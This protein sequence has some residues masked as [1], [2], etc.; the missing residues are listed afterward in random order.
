MTEVAIGIGTTILA[1][2]L[3]YAGYLLYK[4][5]KTDGKNSENYPNAE[6]RLQKQVTPIIGVK[7][8][9][10]IENTS[11]ILGGKS[12]R[13]S[14]STSNRRRSRSSRRGRSKM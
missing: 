2:G 14:K 6:A 8:D 12:R 13:R 4:K 5:R 7:S 1:A 11:V 9:P 3:G 10:Y